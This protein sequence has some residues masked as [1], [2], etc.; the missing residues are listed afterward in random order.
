MVRRG[1][2]YG[3]PFI[4][5]LYDLEYDRYFSIPITGTIMS[6]S[7]V[8]LEQGSARAAATRGKYSPSAGYIEA[9]VRSHEKA[10]KCLSLATTPLPYLS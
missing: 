4:R 2:R 1:F 9:N 8:I 10:L 5:N 3:R 7:L 6:D